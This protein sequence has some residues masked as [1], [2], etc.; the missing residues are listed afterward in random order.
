MAGQAE[1]VTE[2]GLEALRA[3]LQGTE[4]GFPRIIAPVKSTPAG[5]PYLGA[6]GVALLARPQVA[7]EGLAD[8]LGGFA[9]SLHFPQYLD[10]PTPLSPAAQVCKVAGQLCY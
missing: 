2:E 5:T 6:P 4:T 7:I 9:P 3:Q 8:F 1:Q 10:D